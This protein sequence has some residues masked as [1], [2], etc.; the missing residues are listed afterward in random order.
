MLAFVALLLILSA[1]ATKLSGRSGV[2]SL[3]FFLLLGALARATPWFAIP[4]PSGRWSFQI[5]TIALVLIL[6]DGG[7]NIT[8]RSARLV[9]APALVLALAG[10]VVTAS[11][12]AVIGV[13]TGLAPSIAMLV[14]AVVSSTDAAAVFAA[15][16]GSQL[17]LRERIG[18]T[19]EL[20]SAL[21][22][23]VAFILTITA[24]EVVL[25]GSVNVAEEIGAFALQLLVG[26]MFGVVIGLLGRAFLQR[27]TLG[28]SGLYPVL[29]VA[30]AF[31]AFGL[32]T[33]A[34]GSGFLAVAVAAILLS[35]RHMPYRAGV[36]RVHNALAW[37]AQMA[38]FLLLGL[39][40]DPAELVHH[41]ARGGLLALAL[42]AVARPIAVLLC[43]LPFRYSWHERVFIALTGLRGAVPI[44]LATYPM[45]R[46]VRGA[47]DIFGLV[48]VIV[49]FNSIIPGAL[50]KYLAGALGIHRRGPPPPPT[51][52]E[53]ASRAEYDGEFV[54]YY[55]SSASAV[56]GATVQELPLPE[57]CL[58]TLI[59]R[60][61]EIVPPKGGTRI[62]AGD[63]VL[64]FTKESDKGLTDLL[65]GYVEE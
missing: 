19:I 22:D 17:Q 42:G 52:I 34:A 57:S 60:G 15:L 56:A 20:E 4:A 38:M 39:S 33:L 7:L 61:Q 11:L 51:G 58:V 43:L 29:T 2:P 35:S 41:V 46:H 14:G 26:A 30:L 63:H 5:G 8:A 37:L 50:V 10:T 23:P 55:I 9:L 24:T 45:I 21:N 49:A 25:H 31:A 47:S 32:A 16:R 18:L 1:L 64:V 28:V 3:L 44:V 40:I 36:L 27:V 6:F 54:S 13:A 48:F 65:F 62:D 12:V 53:I 59:V